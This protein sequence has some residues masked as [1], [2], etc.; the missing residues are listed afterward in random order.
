MGVAENVYNIAVELAFF[1]IRNNQI[2]VIRMI[3][4]CCE[5]KS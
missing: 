4:K 1:R 3:T 2:L 5:G